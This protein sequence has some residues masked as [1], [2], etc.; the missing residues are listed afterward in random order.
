MKLSKSR[1]LRIPVSLLREIGCLT[2]ENTFPISLHLA[3]DDNKIILFYNCPDKE[4][5]DVITVDDKY[6]IT[7]K[8]YVLEQAGII[9][10]ASADFTVS[11]LKK[12]IIIRWK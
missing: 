12:Q 7:L 5:N 2:S 3:I 11:A 1:R 9:N 10:S 8:K 4:Y 6:R